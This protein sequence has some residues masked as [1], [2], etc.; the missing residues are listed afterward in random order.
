[1]TEKRDLFPPK[2]ASWLLE[3]V[4]FT[5]EEISL[6]GDFEE[7][8]RKRVGERSLFLAQLWFWKQILIS[9]PSF[10]KNSFFWSL[11]M[12]QNYFKIALR[13]L[14]KYKAY[15]FI[16][17]AGLA[18]GITCSVLMFMWVQEELSFDRF[19]AN[20]GEL[21][22]ILLDP[23]GAAATHEAVSP[24]ILAR[25]MKEE[26]PEVV[27]ATRLTIHGRMLF[28]YE[29]K[30][31]FEQGGL[32]TDPSFFEMFDFPFILGN[33]G[34]ALKELRSL[35]LT[36]SVAEKY[37]GNKNPLGEIITLNNQKD[38]TVTGIIAD[39]PANSHMQ[40]DFVRPFELFRESGRDLDNW[41]DVSFY[42]YAQLQKG[43]SYVDVNSKLK[44]MVERED[45]AHNLYYLQPLTRI[46]LHSNFNFDFASHG[47]ILYV[48]IFA[49]ATLFVLLIACINFMNLAT[50][51][52]A[53]R[54]KEVGMRKVIGACKSDI[55][56]QFYGESLLSS[57]LALLTAIVLIFLLLPAFNSLSGKDL[58]FALAG[59][60]ELY[61][62]L[63]LITLFTG[64]LSGSYPALFLSAFHPIKVLRGAHK[65]GPRGV[66]FRRI[67]VM[68]QFSLTIILLIGTLVVHSQLTHIRKQNLG[69]D[70][71]QIA[72][73]GLR[74]DIEENYE[75]IKNELLNNA[76]IQNV[77]VTSS[78]PTHIGSGT[79]GA[80]WEGKDQDIR[81]Q[82]QFT[83]VDWDYL[84]TFKMEMAEGRFFSREHAT[85]NQ[86]FVLNE[87]AIKAMGLESPIGKGFR[88]FGIDGTIIGVVKD[89][90]Y[91]S[92][93]I[94]IEPLFMAV[95]PQYYSYLCARINEGSVEGVVAA[96]NKIWN[97][98]A[99]G[100]PFEYSFLDERIDNLYRSE[101]RMGK[102][103]NSF[104]LLAVF[105][106]C[107]GLFGMTSFTAER[108]TKEIGI[109][110]VLGAS[111][112]GI[113]ALLSKESTRLV[114]LSNIIA[115]PVA[116][117][118]M[119]GWLKSFAYRTKIEIWIFF[120]SAFVSLLIAVL[121]V[122]YQSIKAALANPAASIRYE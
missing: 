1:M 67:L 61:F 32:L 56:K 63:L 116:Y 98:F 55:V 64:V 3:K 88:A 16:N 37:F 60:S 84:D 75:I 101:Q 28:T 58:S 109:R 110:K 53:I 93:H 54:A 52:S 107:L 83:S 92:L 6:L 70:Q 99:P 120:A 21:H 40:F 97:R 31:Q 30:N 12:I 104:T 35:V 5:I 81:I 66:L 89:F 122:S 69:Y 45:P 39:V 121:T 44:E 41:G 106:A 17:I 11:I 112:P 25:K 49:A 74:G 96:M 71:E 46:H 14:R 108:R 43:A 76:A 102:V 51:R 38:Y 50:A 18:I 34:T 33:P 103:F 114:L 87:T 72:V 24:P 9:V 7:E 85:D 22:R 91:K 86:A 8:Y 77:S 115:W 78:L 23:Q 73:M 15:S 95:L 36:E 90:N 2:L 19:H 82:M 111:I 47:N 118:A 105:I 79:S 26:I 27:N 65:S 42:T 80:W 4:I 100:F 119:N 62:G 57:F 94:E 10:L 59:N 48:Y 117:F 20:A 29:D 113:V 13:T 68:T